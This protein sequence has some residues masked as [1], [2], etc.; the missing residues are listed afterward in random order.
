MGGLAADGK[1]WE[2]LLNVLAELYVATGAAIDWRAV[3]QPWAGRKVPLPTYPFQR[4][5]YW[6]EASDM[7]P[8]D[9]AAAERVHPLL[10]RRVYLAAAAERVQFESQ[11]LASRPPF[12]EQ[13]RVV[14][15]PILPASGFFEIPLA[16]AREMDPHRDLAVEGMVLEQAMPFPQG[17]RRIVQTALKPDAGAY[18]FELYSRPARSGGAVQQLP[19]T[20]HASGRLA[21][22][23]NRS[24]PCGE[25]WTN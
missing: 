1:E 11:L 18:R 24:R 14:G 2:G 9:I 16:A 21:A 15:M 10:G 5:R 17:V 13:H 23:P 19:W 6:V 25:T 4:R 12:L 3:V 8:A 22:P 20:L 7:P